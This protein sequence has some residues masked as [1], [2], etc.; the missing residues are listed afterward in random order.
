[1]ISMMRKFPADLFTFTEEICD[2]KLHFLCSDQRL[3]AVNYYHK[4][5]HLGCCS[6]PRSASGDCNMD[7]ITLLQLLETQTLKV[8]KII[9][10]TLSLI[11]NSSVIVFQK[12]SKANLKLLN[13]FHSTGLLVYP[14]KTSENLWFSD[15]S[16]GCGKRPVL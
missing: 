10:L 8:N 4:A 13:P 12:T 5:L 7:A 6:S 3:K 14:P 2:E 9:K 1:M 15:V 16:R 11:I